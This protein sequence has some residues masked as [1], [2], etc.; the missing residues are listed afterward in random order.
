MT[1]ERRRRK[2]GRGGNS[3][4]ARGDKP[5]STSPGVFS[6]SLENQK[7]LQVCPTITKKESMNTLTT[8]PYLPAVPSHGSV[9]VSASCPVLKYLT[10]TCHLLQTV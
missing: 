4:G 6:Q 1:R 9:G 8:F 2:R 3:E 7:V 5:L 10:W